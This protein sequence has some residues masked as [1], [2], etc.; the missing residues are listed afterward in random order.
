MEWINVL[1]SIVGNVGFP[2]AVAGFLLYYI[3]NVSKKNIEAISSLAK[4]V[5]NN[6]KAIEDFSHRLERLEMKEDLY[7][8]NNK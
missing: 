6:T 4:V 8:D 7:H 3:F 2:I 1:T 5:E